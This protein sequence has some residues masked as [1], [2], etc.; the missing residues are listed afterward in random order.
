MAFSGAEFCTGGDVTPRC[1]IEDYHAG[2]IHVLDGGRIRRDFLVPGGTFTLTPDGAM[3]RAGHTAHYYMPD[4]QFAV[5]WPA[6]HQYDLQPRRPRP[7]V[8]LLG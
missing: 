2:E 1:P 5:A 4:G 8:P 7:H 6:A 3:Q